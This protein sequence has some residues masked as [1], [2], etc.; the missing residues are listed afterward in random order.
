MACLDIFLDTGGDH[1]DHFGLSLS[2]PPGK[3][4]PCL[5]SLS[6]PL[7]VV[8]P[9]V[10]LAIEEVYFRKRLCWWLEGSFGTGNF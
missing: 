9:A 5:S 8:M 3:S 1:L 4:H 10:T 2:S 6:L 7:R